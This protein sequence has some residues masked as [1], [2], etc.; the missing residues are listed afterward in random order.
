MH[1]L[2]LLRSC[3]RRKASRDGSGKYDLP[4][5]FAGPNEEYYSSIFGDLRAKL[6]PDATPSQFRINDLPPELL[7][8]VFY[9]YI[10]LITYRDYSPRSPAPYSWFVIRHVCRAWR[11]VA[12]AY[13]RLSSHIHLFRL[14][15][16]QA[17]LRTSGSA[18]IRV[19]EWYDGVS[20]TDVPARVAMQR[21]VFGHLERIVWARVE[22]RTTSV[23]D[24]GP[25][26]KVKTSMLR[27]LSLETPRQNAAHAE[28]VP[29]L[30]SGFTFPHL[31]EFHGRAPGLYLFSS[32]IPATLRVLTI[33]YCFPKDTL[34]E[35]VA[36]LDTLCRLEELTVRNL[37][38]WHEDPPPEVLR[39]RP[40]GTAVTLKHLTQLFI[41]GSAYEVGYNLLHRLALPPTAKVHQIYDSH[42][43]DP[44]Y[45]PPTPFLA[46]FRSA[47]SPAPQSLAIRTNGFET[48]TLHLWDEYIPLHTL[49]AQ[50]KLLNDRSPRFIFTKWNTSPSFVEE[51]LRCLPFGSVRA[52]HL[53][54]GCWLL[55]RFPWHVV[56]PQL[57]ALE[58][59]SVECDAPRQMDETSVEDSEERNLSDLTLM[60]PAL[61]SVVLCRPRRTKIA[62]RGSE[63]L[64]SSLRII[65]HRL[66]TRTEEFGSGRPVA[67]ESIQVEEDE[68]DL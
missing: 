57:S 29:P 51:F 47:D 48:L 28:L 18:P 36:L 67:V 3:L 68:F 13:P 23:L 61:K 27:S 1:A 7:A 25:P 24:L 9:S 49:R 33:D 39:L 46:T 63:N 34:N 6:S 53:E 16:V 21:E 5:A 4:D 54:E 20:A 15:C 52:A 22:L 37:S 43:K 42:A 59:L 26:G 64:F 8:E 56:L 14:E 65:A 11:A 40:R 10:L 55:A 62:G 60:F 66:Q 38:Y 50:A 32:I 12:L 35:F 45:L 44:P 2:R 31:E 41:R 19:Y 30:W 58:E 17:M